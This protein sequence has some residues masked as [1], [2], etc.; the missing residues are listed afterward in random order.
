MCWLL[1]CVCL[2]QTLILEASTSVGDALRKIA[3][4]IRPPVPTSD[5][6]LHALV[7]SDGDR[8]L[9]LSD[10]KTLATSNLDAKVSTR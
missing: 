10:A 6:R 8:R 9:L 5:I 7:K 3:P 2:P 4:W 1:L